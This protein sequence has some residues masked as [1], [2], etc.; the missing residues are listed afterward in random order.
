ML[1]RQVTLDE[2]MKWKQNHNKYD[3]LLLN[4]GTRLVPAEATDSVCLKHGWAAHPGA[5]SCAGD[6][7][8]EYWR[9]CKMYDAVKVETT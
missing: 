1:Y 5:D 8:F 6:G 3:A 7:S 4:D 9:D 2:Y